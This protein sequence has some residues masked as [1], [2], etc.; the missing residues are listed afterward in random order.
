LIRQRALLPPRARTNPP[1]Y[2]PP[3]VEVNYEET[4]Y[5]S[6]DDS[7]ESEHSNESEASSDED[8]QSDSNDPMEV[9]RNVSRPLFKAKRNTSSSTSPARKQ[10][11]KTPL[12]SSSISLVQLVQALHS[13]LAAATE[14]DRRFV[15]EALSLMDLSS[16]NLPQVPQTKFSTSE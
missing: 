16:P 5:I 3:E 2:P 6:T 4:W 12:P 7:C 10:R 15:S 8:P 11:S 9:S 1:M 13:A 14:S